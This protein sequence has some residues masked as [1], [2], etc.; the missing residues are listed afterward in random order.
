MI[1]FRRVTNPPH[2]LDFKTLQFDSASLE[3]FFF[4]ILYVLGGFGV[5][6]SQILIGPSSNL[7][8]EPDYILR[9]DRS[10]V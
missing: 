9:F 7:S 5:N 2:Q 4:F 10:L 6:F 3:F 8:K 1:W